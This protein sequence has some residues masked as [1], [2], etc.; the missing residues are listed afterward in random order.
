VDALDI[1]L[2]VIKD[3]SG[4]VLEIAQSGDRTGDPSDD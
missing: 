4:N 3:N 1:T 2:I